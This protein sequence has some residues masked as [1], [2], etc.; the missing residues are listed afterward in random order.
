MGEPCA[1]LTYSE[2]VINED[3]VSTK[4]DG[5]NT[6]CPEGLS[7]TLDVAINATGIPGFLIELVL[8]QGVP[9]ILVLNPS[10]STP[11][12]SCTFDPFGET[13]ECHSYG[14]T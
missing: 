12:Y 3:D 4:V 13:V 2:F 8:F 7:G 6:A 5:T 11:T 14:Q 1:T 9:T 10:T